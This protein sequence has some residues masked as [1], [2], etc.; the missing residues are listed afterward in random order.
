MTTVNVT[1]ISKFDVLKTVI[2][3]FLSSWIVGP[4]ENIHIRQL[5]QERIDF[6][7]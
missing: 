4:V 6:I 2:S 1:L 5:A 7:Y 3:S